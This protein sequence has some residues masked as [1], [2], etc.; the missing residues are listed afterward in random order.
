MKNH[1]GNI[2]CRCLFFCVRVS[3]QIFLLY[4]QFSYSSTTNTWMSVRV[5]KEP[6]Q[7]KFVWLRCE[8]EQYQHSPNLNFVVEQVFLHYFRLAF[9]VFRFLINV[10]SIFVYPPFSLCIGVEH[11]SMESG[12]YFFTFFQRL[13][14]FDDLFVVSSKWPNHTVKCTGEM[15]SKT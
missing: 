12:F 1:L 13:F 9:F 15:A 8:P 14:N 6:F 10:P 2:M 7:A 5:I 11:S 4:F 3:P